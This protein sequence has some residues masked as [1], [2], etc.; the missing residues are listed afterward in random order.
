MG[1]HLFLSQMVNARY[2]RTFANRMSFQINGIYG[3]GANLNLNLDSYHTAGTAGRTT[4]H[5]STPT[6]RCGGTRDRL[7]FRIGARFPANI[8]AGTQPAKAKT[9]MQF[10]CSTNQTSIGP[11]GQAG[12]IC[13]KQK[14]RNTRHGTTL[15]SARTTANAISKTTAT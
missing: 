4:S 12:C 9:A 1:D 10:R 2:N 8:S 13:S 14:A 5:L 15:L 6:S 7:P 11:W 3:F